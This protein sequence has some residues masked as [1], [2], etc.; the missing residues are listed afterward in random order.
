M[1]R[2]KLQYIVP[3]VEEVALVTYNFTL[4]SSLEDYQDNPIFAPEP[5]GNGNVL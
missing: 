2:S 3:Q 4:A 1:K 5:F